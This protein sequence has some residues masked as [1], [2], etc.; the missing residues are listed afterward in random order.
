M[1]K[2]QVPCQVITMPVVNIMLLEVTIQVIMQQAQAIN[3]AESMVRQPGILPP[4][5]AVHSLRMQLKLAIPEAVIKN[6]R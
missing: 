1:I 2:K 5:A 3:Q 4:K 6:L